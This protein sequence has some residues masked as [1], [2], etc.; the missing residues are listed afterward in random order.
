METSLSARAAGGDELLDAPQAELQL[1]LGLRV[2]DADEALAGGA[3]SG[4]GEDRDA[5]LAEESARQLL[6][7]K[8]GALDVREDVEGPLRAL[9]AHAR[10][11]VEAVD[12]Q[13]APVREVA[14]EVDIL[15][16]EHTAC[17]VLRRVDDEHPRL[18]RDQRRELFEVHT[19]VFLF[20]QGDRLRH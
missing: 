8:A 20:T 17:R 12:D 14:D 15:F 1:V 3:E 10:D 16:R 19:E 11:L 13:V 2:G 5:R 9:A 4:P 7:V 6:L 18:R